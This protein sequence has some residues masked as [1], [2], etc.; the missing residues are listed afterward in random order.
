I[1]DAARVLRPGGRLVAVDFARH[2]LE[3]LRTEHAHRRLGFADNEIKGW[4]QAAG[5]LPAP[6]RH[7][8]SHRLTV[9][10]WQAVRPAASRKRAA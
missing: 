8:P 5:L 2:D 6:T 4:F 7:L 9:V 3:A 1:A 10:I